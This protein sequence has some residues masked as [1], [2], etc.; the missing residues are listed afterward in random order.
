MRRILAMSDIHDRFE[1]FAVSRLPDAELCIVAGDL[2]NHGIRGKWE[3]SKEDLRIYAADP[4]YLN[5]MRVWQ[6]DE[7]ARAEQWL[8][9]LAAR[10]PVLWIPG[11]HDIGITCRS[12][13]GIRNC[14]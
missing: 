10:Y 14:T 11:N 5:L 13:A 1:E 8:R 2:T 12:F 6:G 7:I 3:T 4:V 9:Q